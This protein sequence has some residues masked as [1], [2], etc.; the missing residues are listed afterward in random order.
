V[1]Q[2][3][4]QAIDPATAARY[5]LPD[6]K[7]WAISPIRH[8]VGVITFDYPKTGTNFDRLYQHVIDDRD[9]YCAV[10]V[11]GVERPDLTVIV[12]N[13]NGDRVALDG[14]WKFT[15][16]F[17]SV[18]LT[19]AVTA[20]DTIGLNA[21]PDREFSSKTAG[22]IIRTLVQEAQA[23][24]ALAGVTTSSFSNTT[25]SKG[26]AWAS[27]VTIEFSPG[28][29]LFE[30]LNKLVDI[31]L[32]EWRMV[33]LDLR[34]YN[35]GTLGVDRTLQDPPVILRGGQS[36]SDA[37][38]TH[39][40]EDSKTALLVAGSEGLYIEK[41]DATA[42][43]RRGRRIEGYVS[44]GN[45]TD[46]GT[47]SAFGDAT[48]TKVTPGVLQATHGIVFGAGGPEPMTDFDEGDWI[49]S[50]TGGGLKRLQVAQWTASGDDQGI[51]KGSVTLNDLIA[52]RAAQ[53][54]RLID[55]LAGG[56]TVVGSSTPPPALDD[57]LSPA[58]PTGLTASSSA[59]VTDQGITQAQVSSNWAD[60]T[61]NSDGSALD[62][63]AGYEVQFAYHSGQGLPTEWQAAGNSQS[64]DLQFSGLVPAVAIDLRVRAYDDAN[65][66]GAW[67]AT[68]SLT[69]GADTTA[70]P[71]P[72]TPIVESYLGILTIAWD[73]KG[74]LGE[75]MPP[76]F[77]RVDVYASTT[78]GFTPGPST[79]ID[80]LRGAGTMPSTIGNYG[81]TWYGRL[82]AVD[83]SGNASAASAQDSALLVQAADGDIG[84]LSIGKLTA[85]I[86][87]ALM[88][89]SG[90]IRTAASGSRVE[91]DTTGFRCFF[92]TTQVLSF[93]ISSGAL[94]LIGKLTSGAGP[95]A[96]RSVVIDPSGDGSFPAINMYPN[97]TLQRIK[98][99]A[100]NDTTP[101]G[102]SAPQLL[103]QALNA[104]GNP[105][106]GKIQLW[107]DG[108]S[109]QTLNTGG[110]ADGGHVFVNGTQAYIGLDTDDNYLVFNEGGDV[111]FTGRPP[112]TNGSGFSFRLQGGN[113][114][115]VRAIFSGGLM[116]FADNQA[117]GGFM[118]L[119]GP[120]GA[121]STKAFTIAHPDDPE[122][123]LVH[124]CL[125]GPEAGVYYRGVAQLDER[126][127]ATVELPSYFEAATRQ[128]GRTVQV[129]ALLPDEEPEYDEDA[130]PGPVAASLPREGRFRIR[131][132]RLT[133]V[134]WLVHAERADVPELEAEPLRSAVQ[135][136]RWGPYTWIE[137]AQGE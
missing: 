2:L 118:E 66:I 96:G 5:P 49:Y 22:A 126:G 97:A 82:V 3:E 19:E 130:A 16:K 54:Q 77:D 98:M 89:V 8:A 17:Q 6:I 45:I 11:D 110:A 83:T 104:S 59:Y 84:S 67:S 133:R 103:I 64:S 47:L 30:I 7:T 57:G 53:L 81:E 48:L 61:T 121:Y 31:G 35:A 131:G 32:C 29:T 25:D 27:I 135:V 1:R 122:R 20:P 43:A 33:G 46:S 128:D 90:I 50:D 102:G 93:S 80:S 117:G 101:A 119:G 85:G 71:I 26:A 37:P 14:T 70:P 34:L 91:L 10:R 106:G 120:T 65:N 78:S 38:L 127:R 108:V 116:R 134:S 86:M 111:Y 62:D 51:V 23:R 99:T 58:A 125:E 4:L 136:T 95:G 18:L 63:L 129:T 9:L 87:S 113:V 28:G 92:G 74:S 36:I 15:G 124:G 114:A 68:Y 105:D 100:V 21:D 55:E 24:G 88:T 72:S 56:S 42:T 60:V 112:G 107:D 73:G 69:T 123:W 137:E 12:G 76:D 41:V 109:L 40:V 115:G 79:Y 44:S 39:S 52:S 13:S 75:A 94:S 132:P